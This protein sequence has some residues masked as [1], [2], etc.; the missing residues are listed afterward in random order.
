MIAT[1][2]PE[3]MNGLA[4]LDAV[5]DTVGGTTAEELITKVKRGGVFAS[6][7]GAPQN[8][9]EYPTVRVVPIYV[10]PDAEILQL[11]AAAVKG[12]K[13][14]IPMGPTIPLKDA[15]K[16]HAAA[17]KGGIGKVLLVA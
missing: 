4:Q 12:G 3:A 16:G 13:L 8:A 11:M 2:D 6:V 17:E 7:L 14:V 10:R 9:K 5:A 1:D 15:A